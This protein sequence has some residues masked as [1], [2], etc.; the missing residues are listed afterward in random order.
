MS[1][2][3]IMTVVGTFSFVLGLFAIV[4]G[5]TIKEGDAAPVPP[6]ILILKTC[7]IPVKSAG[8][9]VPS[10]DTPDQSGGQPG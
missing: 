10:A 6:H 2:V 1:A 8:T 3:I 5:L 9:Q 4:M 7:G